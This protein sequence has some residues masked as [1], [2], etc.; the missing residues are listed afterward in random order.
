MRGTSLV[1]VLVGVVGC[2][3]VPA[4]PDA[5]AELCFD[6]EDNDGNGLA[7]CADP[8]CDPTAVC[9]PSSAAQPAGVM[10]AENEPCPD[11]FDGGETLIHRGLQASS[12]TGCG[13]TPGDTTCTGRIWLYADYSDCSGDVGLSGGALLGVLITPTCT[14]MP[15]SYS[16]VPGVRVAITGEST[17]AVN[18]SPLPATS[19]WTESVKFCRATGAGAGCAAGSTCVGRAATPAEQCAIADSSACEGDFADSQTWYTDYDDQRSCGA[20]ICNAVGG[21]CDD[22]VVHIGDDYTCNP[23]GDLDVYE[24]ADGEKHCDSQG[25][26]APPARLMGTPTAP[27]S[28]EA[29]APISGTI[30][31]SG[32]TTLCCA[33]SS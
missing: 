21:G 4:A 28:C 13:C 10:V 23:S 24:V 25:N 6:G 1:L 27:T 29:S 17:C 9:V 30:M 18:G 26:Y 7:D 11:G 15:I 12:C 22:V 20:C 16:N 3:S 5:A 14:E 8:G 31:P 2:G 32:E 19:T 33:P